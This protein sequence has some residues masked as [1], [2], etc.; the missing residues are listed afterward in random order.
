MSRAARLVGIVVL[1]LA[2]VVGLG[3]SAAAADGGTTLRATLTVAPPVKHCLEAECGADEVPIRFVDPSCYAHD[4]ADA[5]P[6]C[7]DI[8]P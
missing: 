6:W 4:G 8:F 1:S 7:Q 5:L 3:A 2:S